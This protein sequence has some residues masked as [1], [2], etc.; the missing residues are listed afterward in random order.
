MSLFFATT[1]ALVRKQK[2]NVI[3]YFEHFTFCHFKFTEISIGWFFNWFLFDHNFPWSFMFS[4]LLRY[5]CSWSRHFCNSLRCYNF[6]F[7]TSSLFFRCVCYPKFN[8][9]ARGF[10]SHRT[11]AKDYCRIQ[12]KKHFNIKRITQ[13]TQRFNI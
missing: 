1:F 3:F 10:S 9:C 12:C 5:M 7:I 6:I 13:N 11:S 2:G 4:Q 8:I